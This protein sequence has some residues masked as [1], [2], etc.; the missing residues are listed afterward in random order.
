MVKLDFYRRDMEEK[1]IKSFETGHADATMMQHQQNQNLLG[2]A[3]QLAISLR[4]CHRQLAHAARLAV[5]GASGLVKPL[6]KT[7]E[8]IS[9]DHAIVCNTMLYG[10]AAGCRQ[11]LGCH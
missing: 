8:A 1:L 2:R 9:P 4:A 7:A 3:F 11:A 6:P 10:M 5:A